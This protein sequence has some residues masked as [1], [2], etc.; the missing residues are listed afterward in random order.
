MFR[1]LKT[2][3]LPFAQ[4]ELDLLENYVLQYGIRG[5]AWY[6]QKDWIYGEASEALQCINNLRRSIAAP[7]RQAQLA[8][9]Q[10]SR[11]RDVVLV[12]YQLLETFAVPKQLEQL[13]QEAV[14]ANL[15]ETVQVHQQIWDKV[16]Q[17]FDQLVELL[18][19]ALLTAEEF[20]V[21]LQAAFDNLDLGLLPSSLDQVLI[22]VLAHSRSRN[23][24]AVFVLGLNEGVFPAKVEQ[25]GFFNDREKETLREMGL[26]LS[27]GSNEQLYEEQFLI[28]LA[29]T[30]ASH[31]LCLS[32]SLSDSDG[33]ALRPST[34][35]EGLHRLYP[36]LQEQSVQWPPQRT[37][38][39]ACLFEPSRQ[40]H[41]AFGQPLNQ[42]G[43][44]GKPAAVGR[45]LSVVCPASHTA[46]SAC[47]S[48]LGA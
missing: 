27:P 48:E 12:L 29:L 39:S 34:I 13:C 6:Q 8:L 3:L 15:L 30:R 41:G 33:K 2:A 5:S 46:V 45:A 35:V 7:L 18:P 17:I 43:N 47:L 1:F 19:D 26:E 42:A 36:A 23:L 20:A 22:G 4:T 44:A 31:Y 38:E 25:N 21:I 32:Y 28:Y 40:G 9:A 11:A 14:E 24:K 16:I 37:A 10:P